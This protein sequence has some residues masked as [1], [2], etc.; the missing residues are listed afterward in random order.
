MTTFPA[1]SRVWTGGK[2]HSSIRVPFREIS[3]QDKSTFRV[4]DTQGPWGDPDVHMR[5]PH[6]AVASSRILDSRSQ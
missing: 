4:Y 2:L 5:C 1:S 3:L 6:G